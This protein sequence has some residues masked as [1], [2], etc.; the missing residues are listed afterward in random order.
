MWEPRTEW[1]DPLP[2]GTLYVGWQDLQSGGWE[3]V[4]GIFLLD[5]AFK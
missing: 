2:G 4:R 5:F 3:V 1:H